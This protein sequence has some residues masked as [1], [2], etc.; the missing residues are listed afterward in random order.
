MRNAGGGYGSVG[1]DVSAGLTIPQRKVMEQGL[2]LGMKSTPGQASGSRALQQFEAKLESQPMTSGPFNAIK[3]TNARVLSREAA[4]SIGE[5]SDTLD[6]ATLDN[7]FTRI[8]KVFDDAADDVPRAI[9][10]KQFLD[11]FSSVQTELQGVSDGFSNNKLIGTLIG[12]AENGGAS[13]KQLQALTSKLGKA[14]YREMTSSSGD[15]ELGMGLYQMK[16]YVDDLL[17]S[18]MSEARSKAFGE[19]RKQYRNL[20]LLTSRVGIINPSTG[21]VSGASLANLLQQKD[22]LGFLRGRNQT[23]MYNAARFAQAF[24]PIVG[25]SGTATRSQVQGLTD[26]AVRIP[27]NIAARAYTSPIVVNL[28]ARAGAASQAAGNASRNI[29]GTAPFYAPYALPGQGALL[30]E[31]LGQ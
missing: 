4:A 5:V 31:E 7:A 12:H 1:D 18:G 25:D 16:D 14:A 9:D 2:A 29:L 24:K 21:N 26:L 6:S 19:A 28:A 8:S 27:Y 11:K 17:Q 13:G 30:G 23:G 22:K 15:R 10:P 3:E 20:M